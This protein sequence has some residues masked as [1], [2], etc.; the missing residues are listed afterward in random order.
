MLIAVELSGRVAAGRLAAGWSAIALQQTRKV[1]AGLGVNRQVD[2]MGCGLM[3]L[4]WPGR[5]VFLLAVDHLVRLVDA[6]AYL[7]EK[8]GLHGYT[9]FLGSGRWEAKIEPP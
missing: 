1:F 5:V 8:F 7:L 9:L 3:P 2:G 6:V 4:R